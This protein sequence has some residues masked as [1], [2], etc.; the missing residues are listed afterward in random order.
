MLYE[1]P[2][3]RKIKG[4]TNIVVSCGFCKKDI[5]LYQKAGRGRLLRMYLDRII[6]SAVD[7]APQPATL[8]CPYCKKQLAT[9]V[10][11]RRKNI[12]AYI[13]IRSAYNTKKAE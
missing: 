13:L 9:R 3:C 1:N 2:F 4:S 7:L 8:C 12:E 10:L 6:R 5:A 11:L